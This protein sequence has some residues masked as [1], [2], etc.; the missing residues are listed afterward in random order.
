MSALVSHHRRTPRPKRT[1][2]TPSLAKP[3]SPSVLQGASHHS[4]DSQPRARA[5]KR[6]ANTNS[7]KS[8]TSE[9]TDQS[10]EAGPH[11]S[12]TTEAFS[13][14]S[15]ADHTPSP[16]DPQDP[17]DSQSVPQTSAGMTNDQR[18]DRAYRLSVTNW[19]EAMENDGTTFFLN[20]ESEIRVQNIDDVV[21]SCWVE[22]TDETSK[23]YYYN[24]VTGQTQW[25]VPEGIDLAQVR[26]NG[27][28]AQKIAELRSRDQNKQYRS[29]LR[30]YYEEKC[31]EK[32]RQWQQG[33][34]GVADYLQ[35]LHEII[36]LEAETRAKIALPAD[37]DSAQ[38]RKAWKRALVLLH[39]DK[40]Q[41]VDPEERTLR[42]MVFDLLTIKFRD[43]LD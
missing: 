26:L 31:G 28:Q 33:K 16:Q 9:R 23:P 35:G 11:T 27:R 17:T 4:A 22:F 41:D 42:G 13:T 39:P 30:M 25:E 29:D 38:I 19:K 34:R 1:P 32:I 18:R 7:S 6:V 40:I 5:K 2:Q 43:S 24:C 37:A 15:Q 12:R 3:L 36:P 21:R 14:A 10:H 8:Q 20:T